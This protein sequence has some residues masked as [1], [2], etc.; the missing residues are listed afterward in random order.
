MSIS[1]DCKL[2]LFMGLVGFCPWIVVCSR[3]CHGLLRVVSGFHVFECHVG[4]Y[5]NGRLSCCGLQVIACLLEGTPARTLVGT[6][7]VR[8]GL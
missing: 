4:L 7:E 8:G 3:V 2:I 6:P 5:L 1:Q